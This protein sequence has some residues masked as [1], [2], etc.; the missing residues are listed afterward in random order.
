LGTGQIT[1]STPVRSTFA[2]K[3][4]R[5]NKLQVQFVGFCVKIATINYYVGFSVKITGFFYICTPLE[6]KLLIN[7]KFL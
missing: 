7:T 5:T 3:T 1:G 4:L 6:I 2:Q